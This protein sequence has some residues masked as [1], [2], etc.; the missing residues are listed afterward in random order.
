M[1]N[2]DDTAVRG[3]T[4]CLSKAGLAIGSTTSKAKIAAPNGAGVD[5]AI[6]G[7]LYHKADTDDAVVLTT[8]NNVADGYTAIVLVQLDSSGTVSVVQG[9]AVAN[10]AVT[11]GTAVIRWPAPTV[12]KCPIGALKLKNASGSAFV[13]GTTALSAITTTYI[14]LFAIPT[15]PLTS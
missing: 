15:A 7:V 3:G 5:F 10:A 13:G 4:V 1:F 8:A 12:N 11:A 9:T 6:D 14:D 2:L